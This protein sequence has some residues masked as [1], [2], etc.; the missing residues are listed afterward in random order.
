MRLISIFLLAILTIGIA[1]AAGFYTAG[2]VSPAVLEQSGASALV[3]GVP[4]APAQVAT[5][6]DQA[7]GVT[8]DDNNFAAFWEAL[9]HIQEDYYGPAPAATDLTYGAIRGSL[10]ALDDPFTMF[11]DPEITEIQKVELEGEFEGIG[12]YVSQNELGQLV[13][14]TP[15]RGQPAE[16]AGVQAGD[17]VLKVDDED[18][19]GLDVNDSV[20][21]IRGPKGT[22]VLLTIKR[23]DEPDLLEIAVVRDRIEIPSVAEAKTLTDEGAPEVGYVQITVF[24]EETKV[25]LDKALEELRAEGVKAL[26]LDLR[27]NPG[28]YLDTAIEVASEFIGDGV[29]VMQEDSAG[30]RKT[31]NASGTGLATDLPLVVLINRGSASA[32]EIVAGAIRDDKRGLLVGEKTFGKGSVQNVHELSDKSQLR[33]TVAAWLTPSGDK[34]HKVGIAPDIEVE[35]T[36]DDV[37]NE[38][39]PQLER[40]I[41]AA[42]SLLAGEKP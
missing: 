5:G 7:A 14:Q 42:R 32:S 22:T 8:D 29:V 21:L 11:T 24:A 20:L 39:D 28:G 41:E 40:A 18:I 6:S 25:E 23:E 33:V 15:M 9:G 16:K 2:R 10:R 34:I 17:I 31:A 35:R 30:N 12:A 4:G 3:A 37:K 26:I 1:Y 36:A 38:R 13:I 19:S 27:N